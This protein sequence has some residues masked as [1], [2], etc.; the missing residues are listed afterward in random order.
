MRKEAKKKNRY[1]PT[2][3][4]TKQQ[5]DIVREE[6]QTICKELGWLQFSSFE[7]LADML[8]LPNGDYIK[9]AVDK[10]RKQNEIL[11]QV[12]CRDLFI[13]VVPNTW[14]YTRFVGDDIDK[15]I[16]RRKNN[17]L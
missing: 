9:L 2:P 12:W 13:S 3:K 14:F 17:E 7:E 8:C 6:I 11:L 16:E 4:L 1:I 5:E 15:Y 10:L